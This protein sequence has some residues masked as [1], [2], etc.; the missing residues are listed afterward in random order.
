M[1]YVVPQGVRMKQD[2]G[3]GKS[4]VHFG[5]HLPVNNLRSVFEKA[6]VMLNE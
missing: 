6:V 4:S 3:L 1:G 2:E 5:N